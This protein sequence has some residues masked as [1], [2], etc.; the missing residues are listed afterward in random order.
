MFSNQMAEENKKVVE[1]KGFTYKA[2]STLVNFIYTGVSGIE[3]DFVQEVLVASSILQV[4][5]K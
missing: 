4:S 2:I 3:V 5:K 1:L